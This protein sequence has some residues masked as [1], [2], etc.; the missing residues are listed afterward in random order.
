ESNTVTVAIGGSS[1]RDIMINEFLADPPDGLAG[2]ANHDGVRDSAAD[3]FVE[4]VNST[5]RD[6]DISGYELLSRSTTG[7]TDITRHRFAGGTIF[8]AGTAL[9]VFGGGNPDLSQPVFGGSQIVKASSGG[10]SLTNSGGV[11]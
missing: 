5:A 8:P 10:L 11:V 2:D 6:L 3:E 9:V 7:A 1:L 4:L